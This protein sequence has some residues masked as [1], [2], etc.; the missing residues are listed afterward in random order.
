MFD[1]TIYNA[2]TSSGD[3]KCVSGRWKFS[4]AAG[5]DPATGAPIRRSAY[6]QTPQEASKRLCD[7]FVNV[8][9]QTI[10]ED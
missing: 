2:Q 9:R 3:E 7:G 5:Y 4:C 10:K 1:K 8:A 6:G